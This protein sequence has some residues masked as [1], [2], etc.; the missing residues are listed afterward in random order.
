MSLSGLSSD[1]LSESLVAQ[2]PGL[3]VLSGWG[4]PG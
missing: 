4:G 2:G 3:P 1:I